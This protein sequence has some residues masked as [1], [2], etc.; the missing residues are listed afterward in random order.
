MLEAELQVRGRERHI[1][2]LPAFSLPVRDAC[3]AVLPELE[4]RSRQPSLGG[5]CPPRTI[6]RSN[7]HPAERSN[8]SRRK[9]C[10]EWTEEP[11][12]LRF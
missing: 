2:V 9:A 4:R 12:L 6:Q 7:G 3:D 5:A 8:H 11:T 10:V 1:P